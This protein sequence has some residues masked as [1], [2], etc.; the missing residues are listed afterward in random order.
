MIKTLNFL[1]NFDII[2]KLIPN[3]I[4]SRRFKFSIFILAAQLDD[5]ATL[6]SLMIHAKRSQIYS[7]WDCKMTAENFKKIIEY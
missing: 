4:Y 2:S 6:K 1:N 5:T 3:C 7:A